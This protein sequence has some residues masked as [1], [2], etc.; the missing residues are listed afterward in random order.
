METFLPLDAEAYKALARNW[1]ATV[2]VVTAR[3]RAS[4]V[5]N[6]RLEL[7]GFTATAFLM[8]SIAPPI[9]AVSVGKSSGADQL[10]QDSEAFAVNL[11]SEAQTE[12]AAAFARPGRERADVWD[13]FGWHTD[14]AGVPLLDGTA[15]AF[16]ARLRQQVDAGDH[17][18]FF[19]DVATLHRGLKTQTLL[20]CNRA[21]GHFQAFDE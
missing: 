21:Y 10:M 15:G 2:T 18:V 16:S 3:R 13:R 14:A 19:G 5:G 1:A 20:Y 9:I 6:G 4:S 8:I 7:D 12:I 17:L 11:L